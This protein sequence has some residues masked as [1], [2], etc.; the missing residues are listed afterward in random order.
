[1][2]SLQSLAPPAQPPGRRIPPPVWRI[3]N[4]FM[5]ALLGLRLPTPLG[6]RLMLVDLTGRKTGRRYRQ[7]VSYVRHGQVLLT[8]GGGNWKRNL[9][10]GQPV[11]LH[12]NGRDQT[13]IPEIV[14]DP[15]AAADLLAVMIAANPAV[16]RFSGI[17]LDTDGR[18]DRQRV[19]QALEHGF[20]IIRWCLNQPPP[21]A[22]AAGVGRAAQA[23]S[24]AHEGHP[25]G[26]EGKRA[27]LISWVARTV[28]GGTARWLVVVVWLV[29]AGV[30]G[31][32]GSKL[33]S[34]ENNDAQT[35]LPG[36]AQ[37]LRALNVASE[38]FGYADV[39]DAVIVYTRAGGMS[40]ADKATLR[41][42]A[43]SL[44]G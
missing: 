3:V 35:W 12:I 33:T 7:P 11:R 26:D 13:A 25:S 28:S 24:T 6:K 8:P 21:D 29:L 32:V 19:D 38:H 36:G 15:D 30:A 14:I 27:A 41:A 20:A 5:R 2:P 18:P 43:A 22:P 16:T 10:P 4:G 42:N 34:V 44:S 9:K 31:S 37:S 40:A 1:M 23:P 17:G 39:S